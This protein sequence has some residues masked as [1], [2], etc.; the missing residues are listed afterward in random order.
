MFKLDLS[1]LSGGTY[2]FSPQL[3]PKGGS[4]VWQGQTYTPMPIMAEG[5]SASTSG[6]LPHP[7]LTVANLDGIVGALVNSLDDLVGGIVTRKRVLA[8]YLDAVNF[9]GGN[10]NADST[11]GFDDDVW[12]IEQKTAETPESIVW[13]LVAASDAQGL[14]IPSRVIQTSNC[15]ASYKNADGSGL[16]PD[17]GSL[18][19]CDHG[20]NTTNGCAVHFPVVNGVQPNIPFGGFPGTNFTSSSSS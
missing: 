16:C 20:L 19:S 13:D 12:V 3:N 18:T 2:Y 17:T 8:K 1:T 5:F 9:P 14:E 7:T 4:I 10:A 6:S 15:P 11:A